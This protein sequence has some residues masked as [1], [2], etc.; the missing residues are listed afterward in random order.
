M[1][2]LLEML[3]YKRP[4]YSVTESAFCRKF[5]API[6][7]QDAAG[8]WLAEIDMPDGSPARTLWS[9]HTDTVHRD[10]GRQIVTVGKGGW[11]ELP[12][13]SRSSC[14]GADCTAGVWL[15]LEMFEAGIPGL[16]IWHAGEEIGG[17]G[18]SELARAN[19]DW[20]AGVDFAIAFD[21]R[22]CD[23]IVTHQARGRTCSDLFATDLA[24]IL[25]LP[26]RA[27][28]TGI[29]T[30][31]ANYEHIVA[32]CTNISVGYEAAHTKAE[33]LHWPTLRALRDAFVTR[34][35]ERL[36]RAYRDPAAPDPDEDWH[37]APWANPWSTYGIG[38][39]DDALLSL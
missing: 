19:P 18:S 12:K 24:E 23:S 17:L 32:E 1:N 4:A 39:D 15:M 8:N 6:A 27:D 35:D 21:R 7:W 29:F 16:Y 37:L 28:P 36:L 5:L 11:I 34:Y 3:T 9:S 2:R 31:T 13:R 25:D 30:D 10:D 33:A 22:G 26:A 14:L 38:D 20:L